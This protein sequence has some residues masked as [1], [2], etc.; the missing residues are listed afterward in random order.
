M[1][2]ASDKENDFKIADLDFNDVKSK[3][4]PML[5]AKQ[6]KPVIFKDLTLESKNN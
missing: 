3:K 4:Q 5:P 1:N 6:L 2:D